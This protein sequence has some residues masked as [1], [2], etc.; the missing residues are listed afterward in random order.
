MQKLWKYL[1]HLFRY[2]N[3]TTKQGVIDIPLAVW[4]DGTWCEESE[5]ED[6]L[7][8]MSDDFMV[9]EHDPEVHQ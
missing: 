2:S 8:F 4:P 7:T 6:Y 5:I 9:V 1:S 3:T